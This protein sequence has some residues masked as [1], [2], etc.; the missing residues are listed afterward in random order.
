MSHYN[1]T[2]FEW[3]KNIGYIG[4]QLN[5]FFYEKHITSTN[6]TLLDFGCGGGYLL[7]NFNVDN[8]I[9]FEINK[10]AQEQCKLFNINVVD[11]F[12]NI[13]NNS[14][15]IIISNHAMEH[16]PYPLYSLKEL[17][18]KLKTNGKIIIVIPCEQPH[19]HGF[20]YDEND[21]NQHLYTWCPQ[22]FGNLAKQAGFTILSCDTIQHQ[23]CPDYETN[24]NTPD[25]HQRCFTHAIKNNNYQIKLV[26][27]KF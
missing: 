1:K 11:S 19:D 10:T 12:D 8:K 22:S 25:F 13:N 14:I 15:D 5:K 21:I 16:V 23:W 18:K 27:T 6:I 20:K 17:Y 2:Y 4:G 3:Q 26:A 7:N 24:W 9:G